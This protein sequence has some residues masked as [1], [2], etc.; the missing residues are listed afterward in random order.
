MKKKSI[1]T[2]AIVVLVVW[3][4]YFD[5][6]SYVN[7]RKA[8][9]EYSKAVKNYES[10]KNKLVLLDKELKELQLQIENNSDNVPQTKPPTSP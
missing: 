1:L 2:V 3:V 6:T 7:F 5:L 8:Q 9:G 4:A 10:A